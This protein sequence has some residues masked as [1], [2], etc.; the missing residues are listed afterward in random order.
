MM[1]SPVR[2]CACA[3]RNY[4][5]CV[6]CGCEG[7]GTPVVLHG[8]STGTHT[9]YN[10]GLMRT[11]RPRVSAMRAGRQMQAVLGKRGH[12]R[13]CSCVYAYAVT[14]SQARSSG[15]HTTV[16]TKGHNMMRCAPTRRSMLCCAPTRRKKMCCASS[17][18]HH[19][20][21][22]DAFEARE[23]RERLVLPVC[24]DLKTE[25]VTQRMT[26]RKR[27]HAIHNTRRQHALR[28]PHA[29][30]NTYDA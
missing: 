1:R 2:S 19:F 27:R 4:V 26:T 3:C 17:A 24:A 14:T 15:R 29:R 22:A 9:D 7:T 12:G 23:H 11:R 13:L 25:Q 16:R 10:E 30:G 21:D 6:Y 20:Q 18:A 8:Y 28:M 5:D